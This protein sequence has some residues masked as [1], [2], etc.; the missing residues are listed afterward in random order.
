MFPTMVIN[1]W[2]LS[3]MVVVVVKGD[4]GVSN[5]RVQFKKD[6]RWQGS[7]FFLDEHLGGVLF[8]FAIDFAVCFELYENKWL[9]VRRSPY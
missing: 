9:F 6:F 5:V 1:D 3:P 4:V 7:Y 2:K 8:L